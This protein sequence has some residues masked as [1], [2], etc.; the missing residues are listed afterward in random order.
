MSFKKKFLGIALTALTLIGSTGLTFADS[1]SINKQIDIDS[2]APPLQGWVY[3]HSSK[4]TSYKINWSHL[5]KNPSSVTDSVS[6]SVSR[7]KFASGTFGANANFKV[8]QQQVGLSA[9]V[10]LG[11]KSTSTTTVTYAIPPYSTYLCRYGSRTATGKGIEKYYVNGN[12]TKS[13]NSNATYSY[14]SYSD[15]VKQ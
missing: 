2:K 5:H 8:L 14:G 3:H 9:E 6:K 15:K 7:E 10:S 11:G 12:V 4:S 1:S 13:R